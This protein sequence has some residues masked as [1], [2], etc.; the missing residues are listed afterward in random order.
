MFC[1]LIQYL[2]CKNRHK[3]PFQFNPF[4][5]KCGNLKRFLIFS[6]FFK[7][8]EEVQC[9]IQI[10]H[11]YSNKQ[12]SDVDLFMYDT[13]TI[14]QKLKCLQ[15]CANDPKCFMATLNR[16]ANECKLYSYSN[17]QFVS[18]AFNSIDTFLK[19]T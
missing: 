10:F 18:S 14:S 2:D 6:I 13:R 17:N 15:V 1:I 7:T 19:I 12:P 9:S 11:A 5:Y 4:K 16:R 3:Y 8:L